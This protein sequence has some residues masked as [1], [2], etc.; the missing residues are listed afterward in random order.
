[1]DFS[2]DESQAGVAHQNAGQKTGLAQRL[3][4]VAYA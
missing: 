4:A 3:E 1:M 2:A